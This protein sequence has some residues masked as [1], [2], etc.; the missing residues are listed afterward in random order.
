MLRGALVLLMSVAVLPSVVTPTVTVPKERLVGDSESG[1]RPVPER[2]AICGVLAA[3][4]ARVISPEMAPGTE[5]L[6]VA[7]IVQ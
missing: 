6:K 2:L 7:V 4:S 5:G 1:A 3:L